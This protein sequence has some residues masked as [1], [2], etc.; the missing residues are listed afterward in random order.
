VSLCCTVG[1]KWVTVVDGVTFEFND[2]IIPL[3]EKNDSERRWSEWSSYMEP[4]FKFSIQ[5]E[6]LIYFQLLDNYKIK[7]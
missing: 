1:Y 7:I 2:M 6:H 3:Y 5:V 4:H